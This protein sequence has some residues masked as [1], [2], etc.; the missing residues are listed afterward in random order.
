M[1]IAIVGSKG[2]PA[3]YGGIQNVVEKLAE[4]LAKLDCDVTVFSYSYYSDVK[5]KK[6]AYKGFQVINTKG[7]RTKHLDAISHSFIATLKASITKEYEIIAFV[8]TASAFWAFIPKLFGKKVV[9][10][11]HGLEFLGYKWSRLDK[12]LMKFLIR[13]TAWPLDGVTSVSSSQIGELNKAYRVKAK[14]IP[15]GIYYQEQKR[16]AKPQKNIL[17]VGRIVQ[18]KGLETLIAAFQAIS[19]QFPQF[20]LKIVGEA[21]YSSPY[22]QQLQKAAG[23]SE[24][25]EFAGSKYGEE[26]SELYKSA[27]CIVIPSHIES[28]SIVLLEALMHN[29]AVICSDIAQ[30][31]DIADGYVEFFEKGSTAALSSKLSYLLEK[32]S[33]RLALQQKAENFPFH[34]YDW[35]TIT[36]E[37][38]NFYEALS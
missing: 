7:I 5:K 9:F 35:N 27:Y 4:G 26:L 11:S 15:N 23:P 3:K 24:K 1:K 20:A 12:L 21:V 14:L 32:Q 30:F 37:Y 28:F 8:S 31:K 2:I 33:N 13:M 16:N 6:F 18:E 22:Y 34:Q 10:H 38:H 19:P 29:G 36:Q 25:I 17:F